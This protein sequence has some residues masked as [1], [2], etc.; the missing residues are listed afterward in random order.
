MNVDRTLAFTLLTDATQL[1]QYEIFWVFFI[2]FN[3]S[4]WSYADGW[5][6]S[7]QQKKNASFNHFWME[8][9]GNRYRFKYTEN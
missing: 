7:K 2:M 9:S 8:C 5:M 3:T 4:E 6:K 1:K